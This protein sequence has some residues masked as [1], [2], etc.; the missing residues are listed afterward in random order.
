MNDFILHHPEI[1]L[2]PN[3]VSIPDAIRPEFYELFS[4]L[5]E[6][7]IL[8]RLPEHIRKARALSHAYLGIKSR[9]TSGDVFKDVQVGSELSSFLTDPLTYATRFLFNPLFDLLTGKINQGDFDLLITNK[10]GAEFEKLL[11]QGQK[12]WLFIA[13]VVMLKPD[14]AR[15]VPL[16]NEIIDDCVSD[17]HCAGA[18]IEQPPD[19][20]ITEM[21]S[22]E[23]TP[24][25]KFL[26]PQV[27]IHS[28]VLNRF[29]ALVW[30]FRDSPM[31]ARYVSQKQEWYD[32][33][34]L[35]SHIEMGKFWPDI[36]VYVS[37]DAN[38]MVLISD[39]FR[40]ARPDLLVE[41]ISDVGEKAIHNF[42]QVKCLCN[43]YQPKIGCLLVSEDIESDALKGL[44]ESWASC[45]QHLGSPGAE[46]TYD[47]EKT[48]SGTSG[49]V[50]E[51]AIQ[52]RGVGLDY[53]IDKLVKA[54]F[55]LRFS[56]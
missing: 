1:Q 15:V 28:T 37:E 56:D 6:E 5:R 47:I 24:F 2:T 44:V 36:A 23:P 31:R 42:K 43:V 10:L 25:H 50:P 29:V 49:A 9:I 33:L 38:D 51:P 48:G 35:R 52:V 46:E 3:V 21:L 53:D 16:L 27:I 32:L 22:L 54:F 17:V 7:L 26:S 55:E 19:S 13:M 8:E 30:E 11:K 4:K 12:A 40:F 45:E 20:V 18:G 34:E 41:I 14:E 39:T